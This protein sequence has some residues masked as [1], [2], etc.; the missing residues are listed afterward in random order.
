MVTIEAALGRE[1]DF[2]DHA[3]G[4]SSG[5]IKRRLQTLLQDSTSVGDYKELAEARI[6]R[7][8]LYLTIPENSIHGP[9]RAISSS[10]A[11]LRRLLTSM[12]IEIAIR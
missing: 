3:N 11:S 10:V 1:E 8:A 6:N 9:L 5:C 4:G 2:K 12:V 7:S